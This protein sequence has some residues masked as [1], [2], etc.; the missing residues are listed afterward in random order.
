MGV[1]I[2]PPTKVNGLMKWMLVLCLTLIAAVPATAEEPGIDTLFEWMTGSFSSAAQAEDDSNYHHITLEMAPIWADRAGEHWIYVEQALGTMPDKPYRQRVYRVTQV[3]DG[4]FVSV[5]YTMPNPEKY[6]GAW[7]AETPL[8]NLKPEDLELREGCTVYLEY[9]AEKERFTGGT[10][11]E[12]CSSSL[13]G[14]AYATSEVVIIPGR[15][16]SW[17]RGFD[18]TGAQVWG[19]EAGPYIFIWK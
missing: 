12:G 19:A 6:V 3:E 14:A 7:Q 13:R 17:D 16:E 8:A 10:R 4:T 18:Q 2:H 9:D 5:V 15:L 1:S 11:G